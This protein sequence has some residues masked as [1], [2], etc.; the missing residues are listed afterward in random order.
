MVPTDAE[1]ID[2]YNGLESYAGTYSVK[3]DIISHHIDASWNQV[4]TGTIQ[5]R[6][7][8]IQG[9]TL[10]IKTLGQK[11]VRTGKE[12]ITELVWIKVE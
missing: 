10:D 4:W 3:G 5:A 6:Q 1:R 11:S 9:K 2:L 12:S 7:F 8:K